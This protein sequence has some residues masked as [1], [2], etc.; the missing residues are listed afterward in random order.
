MPSK[1]FSEWID[2][3]MTYIAIFVILFFSLD[4]ITTYIGMM[5]G[6]PE[7]N[8][9]MDLALKSPEYFI[10]VKAIGTIIILFLFY[11]L[12]K[13]YKETKTTIKI[14]YKNGRKE[15]ITFYDETKREIEIFAWGLLIGI[16]FFTIFVNL[17]GILYFLRG[18]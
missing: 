17:M 6:I 2:K 1:L 8:P 10:L 5:Y 15:D 4:L 16:M 3:R 7:L 13:T 12:F 14:V 9:L 18:V 11:I